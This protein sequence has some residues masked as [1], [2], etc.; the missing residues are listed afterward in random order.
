V[1]KKNK[2]DPKFFVHFWRC[3]RLE[4]LGADGSEEEEGGTFD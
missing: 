3:F 4:N 2:K 1:N